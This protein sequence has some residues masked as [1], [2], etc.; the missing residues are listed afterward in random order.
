MKLSEMAGRVERNHQGSGTGDR[1]VRGIM[2]IE[3]AHT[4][5][6]AVR[7]CQVE[8]APQYVHRGRGEPLTGRLREG[9]LK[10]SSH[11]SAYHVRDGIREKQPAKEIRDI[12]EPRHR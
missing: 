10:R 6:E 11:H 8:R 4:K 5:Y 2:D 3:S 1:C 9:T 12:V 7:N